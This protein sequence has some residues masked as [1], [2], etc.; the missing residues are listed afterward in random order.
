MLGVCICVFKPHFG[1][2]VIFLILENLAGS[3]DR[4][5]KWQPTTAK[6]YCWCV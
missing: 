1:T 2:Y 4:F 3:D 5:S 6:S